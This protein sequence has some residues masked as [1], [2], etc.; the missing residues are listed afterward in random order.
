MVSGLFNRTF[1][2][3]FSILATSSPRTTMSAKQTVDEAIA[4]HKIVIFSKS[5]CPYCRDAKQVLTS[6]FSHLKDQIYIKECVPISL[7][8]LSKS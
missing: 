8:A 1:G 2:A 6:D 3:F 7:R 4:K 5:Y